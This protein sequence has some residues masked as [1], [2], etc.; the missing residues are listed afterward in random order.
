MLENIICAYAYVPL[1][2]DCLVDLMF[3]FGTL[4][5]FANEKILFFV[6]LETISISP[7]M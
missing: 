5:T 4:V 6:T 3:Y 2:M 1:V 7:T